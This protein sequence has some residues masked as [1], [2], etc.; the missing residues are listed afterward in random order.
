MGSKLTGITS[1]ISYKK[2]K[3]YRHHVQFNDYFS[4]LVWVRRV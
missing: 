4:M 1:P 3:Y 2:Q